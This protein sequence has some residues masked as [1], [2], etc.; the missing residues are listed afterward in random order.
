M[1]EKIVDYLNGLNREYA[2]GEADYNWSGYHDNCSHTL[3]N[4]LAAAGVWPF[5]S[6]QS[7]KLRQFFNLSIPANEFADLAL[8]GTTYPLE[9]FYLIYRDKLKHTSLLGNNWLPTQHGALLQRIAVHQNNDL[10]DTGTKLFVLETP[11]LKPKSKRID[12]MF[13]EPR[14]TEIRANLDFFKKRYEEI[15]K[16]QPRNRETASRK[17]DYKRAREIYYTYI[18]QQLNDV[19]E[20]L[21]H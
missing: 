7:F 17:S 21:S 5:K 2:S 8:L 19:N 6:V 4:A 10:Y 16:E 13:N 9:D 20:K 11:F 18:E 14:Y 1:I 12:A 15:L 3:H